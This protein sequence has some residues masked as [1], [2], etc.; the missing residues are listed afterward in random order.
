M[1]ELIVDL[2]SG[3][4]AAGVEGFALS[5]GLILALGPQNVFVLRQG[6]LRSH[7]FVVCLVCSLSD[8]TLIAAGVL[9]MGSVLSGIEGAEFYIAIIAAIFI[10]SYGFLR[11]IS[12]MNPKGIFPDE[13]GD[14]ESSENIKST[15]AAALA[16]T[17]LNPHVYVDTILLIGGA[18][19]RY[20]A[21]DRIAFG[22]GAA[23]A[24]F[25]FFFSLGYGAK[26]LSH[27]LNNPRAWK[28]ID[29]AIACIMFVIAIA[30][31]IPHL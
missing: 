11:I 26:R 18:S 23:T 30:I 6:L 25:V 8:A 20:F 9:G 22:I 4:L 27:I 3:L 12:A 2:M 7:V 5:I 17:F 15:V 16:F 10:S 13:E 24:S 19:S 28:I 14:E 31:M 21:E 29:L 1:Y